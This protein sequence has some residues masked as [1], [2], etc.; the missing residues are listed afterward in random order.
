MP[1]FT[2]SPAHLL[3]HPSIFFFAFV[4]FLFFPSLHD[5]FS[6]RKMNGYIV[7]FRDCAAEDPGISIN[8]DFSV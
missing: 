8:R 5:A 6:A 2:E 3:Q 7:R 1:V 4:S